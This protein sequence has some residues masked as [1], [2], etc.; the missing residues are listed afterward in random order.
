MKTPPPANKRNRVAL[1]TAAAVVVLALIPH[2]A[3]SAYDVTDGMRI[4]FAATSNTLGT[5]TSVMIGQY[6]SGIA[7]KSLAVGTSNII[8]NSYNPSATGTFAAGANNT[9]QGTSSVAFGASNTATGSQAHAVGYMNSASGTSA[10]A[11]GE[12]NGAAGLGAVALGR[13]NVAAA[14]SSLSANY[15]TTAFGNYSTAAGYYTNAYS[16]ASIAGGRYNAP[17]G[18][19]NNTSDQSAARTT[20][21]DGDSLFVI[22]NGT[23]N[24]ARSNALVVKKDGQVEIMKVP[25]KGGIPMYQQ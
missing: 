1:H 16:Y 3:R 14:D 20:W 10:I 2:L 5:N 19:E 23:S 22:G 13:W 6:N 17:V 7:A 18:T 11:L 24:T 25:A 8:G 9:A 21:R 12:N 4:G 15:H